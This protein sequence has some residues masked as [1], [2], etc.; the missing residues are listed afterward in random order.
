LQQQHD[1]AAAK[2]QPHRQQLFQRLLTDLD[3]DA[4]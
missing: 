2:D 1:D 4:S 3:Q